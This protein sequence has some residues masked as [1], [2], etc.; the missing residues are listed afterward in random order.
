M[1]AVVRETSTQATARLQLKDVFV[2]GAWW[3][4][5]TGL[6][7]GAGL[8]GLQHAGW[9]NWKMAQMSV[10]REILWVSP[11]ADFL[12]FAGLALLICA[13]GVLIPAIRDSRVL[14]FI[15]ALMAV[16]DWGSLSGR[17]RIPAVV[18]L[19][20]GLATVWT[21]WFVKRPENRLRNMRRSLPWLAATAV[22]LLIGV[23]GSRWMAERPAMAG[24]GPAN[25]GAPNVLVLIMDTVRADHVGIYG[26]NRATSPRLDRFA[27]QGVLFENAISTSSWTLP[28]HASL[29]TGRFP[30]EHGAQTGPYDG[31][32]LSLAEEFQRRGYRTGAFSANTYFFSRASG[33]GKGFVR[34]EDDFT[35]VRDMAARTLYGRKFYD[36]VLQRLGYDDVPGRKRATDITQS[37]E[38]WIGASG[39]RPFFIFANYF[40]AHDPYL[41]PQPYRSRFSPGKTPGG[42]LNSFVLRLNLR[43]P[44]QLQGEIDAYDGAIAY[45]DDQIGSLLDWIDERDLSKNT[46]VVIL[47]DHGESFGEHGLLMH[48][49]ALYRETIHVPMLLRWPGHVPENVRV[50][51]P[52]SIAS[53][54]AT[55][56]EL[57]AS[58]NAAQFPGPSL[59]PQWRAASP[60]PASD[61]E[62]P[63]AELAQFHFD[64]EKQN[65]VYSGS[66]LSVVTPHWQM[67]EHSAL[68]AMLFNWSTDPGDLHDL[69]ANPEGRAV[70]QGLSRCLHD[71]PRKLDNKQCGV[72]EKALYH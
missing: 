10:A 24:L 72:E 36:F 44:E 37:V 33:F 51:A 66:M 47:S 69:A 26:Y 1:T 30:H 62:F 54:A 61:L 8:L 12:L 28:A 45:I 17:L 35:S 42:A 5:L 58:D 14:G 20:L 29:L 22:V 57:T 65:P 4:L 3:G 46:I 2:L 48:R 27:R 21:R 55:L 68:G 71:N 31:R 49:N 52:V 43:R 32:Y 25:T 50:A 40:D 18:A 38:H 16:F 19:S 70:A 34:F 13:L 56:L 23:Q 9:L 59:V 60:V 11:V 67:I 7:E 64:L 15:F 63:L 39:S 41:P 53:L 6:V